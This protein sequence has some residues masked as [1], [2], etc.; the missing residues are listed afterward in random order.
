MK[1]LFLKLVLF[2]N[3]VFAQEITMFDAGF[4]YSYYKDTRRIKF[5]E[6]TERMTKDSLAA[7]HWKKARIQNVLVNGILLS[8]LAILMYIN[9]SKDPFSNNKQVGLISSYLFI[10]S[11]SIIWLAISRQKSK[12]RAILRYNSLFD[13]HESKQAAVKLKFHP[14]LFFLQNGKKQLASGLAVRLKF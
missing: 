4:S 2:C 1:S 5:N 11:I 8:D 10:S 9:S 13:K 7:A 3:I 14:T 12:S 6:V